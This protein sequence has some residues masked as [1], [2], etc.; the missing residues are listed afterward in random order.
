LAELYSQRLAFSR[1]TPDDLPLMRELHGDQEVM[2]HLSVDGEAWPDDVLAGKLARFVAEQ[3]AHGFSKWKV[4]RRS[5]G[6]FIGRAG[7]SPFEGGVELG[8]I[9][10]RDAWGNGYATECARALLLWMVCEHPEVRRVVAFARPGNIASC[11]VLEK[12]GLTPV[13][14]RPVGGVDHAFYEWQRT[15][16]R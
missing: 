10:R 1:F 6:R 5:D 14:M 8:L 2:R 4:H 16:A 3:A 12:A 7:F 9:F 15:T 13:G 11:R